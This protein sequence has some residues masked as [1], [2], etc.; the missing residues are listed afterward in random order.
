[1]INFV[2]VGPVE[3]Q[4]TLRKPWPARV[5]GELPYPPNWR[6]AVCVLK[7]VRG[8]SCERCGHAR[9][10]SVHHAGVPFAGGRAGSR[11]DKCDLRPENLLVVC[12]ACHAQLEREL[13]LEE[14]E[15]LAVH[16]R[17]VDGVGLV[18]LS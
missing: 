15:R 13:E 11:H 17:H 18:L 6:R 9:R 10:L 1:M 8:Y 5:P 14:E 3:P 2:L 7:R 4:C 12:E 16:R